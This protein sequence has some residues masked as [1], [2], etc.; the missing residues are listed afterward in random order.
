[1]PT[2]KAKRTAKR[3]IRRPEFVEIPIEG[4]GAELVGWLRVEAHRIMW[5]E[6]ATKKWHRVPLDH[7]IQWIKDAKAS[8]SEL[9]VK[10]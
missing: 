3:Q 1:M 4:K 10:K 8:G 2:K 7:F 9:V 5:G 6:R